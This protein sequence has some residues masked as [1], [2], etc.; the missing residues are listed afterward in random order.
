MAPTF[1]KAYHDGITP[2][3]EDHMDEETAFAN[4]YKP[5]QQFMLS[6]VR[7][8]D[9]SLFLDM[10]K[11]TVASKDEM[12]SKV[13]IPAFMISELKKAFE[14]GFL[15]FLPFLVIDILVSSVLMAMGMMM[16]PPVM[17]SL[18]FKVIFF[19]LIDGWYMI[20]GSLVRSYS[21]V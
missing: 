6:N 16:L 21:P 19:V 5:F 18:P 4:M 12:P 1:D 20:C 10:A 8:K 14:I 3:I 9:L 13:L 17:I 15:I 2:L 11:I 7:E